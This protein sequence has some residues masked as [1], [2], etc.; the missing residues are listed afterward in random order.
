MMSL[1]Q[2]RL[3]ID[4][5]DIQLVKLL[6]KRA[7]L[8]QQIFEVKNKQNLSIYDQQREVKVLE[9]VI[10]QNKGPLTSEQ[11]N[12]IF[13]VIIELCRATQHNQKGIKHGNCYEK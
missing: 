12:S 5:V 2:L 3:D 6:N 1:E 11:I 7:F 8:S 10:R 4:K 13:K 9:N